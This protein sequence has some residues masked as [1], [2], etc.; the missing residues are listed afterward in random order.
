MLTIAK[1]TLSPGKSLFK[2]HGIHGSLVEKIKFALYLS[3]STSRN[4]FNLLQEIVF[5][6]LK[7]VVNILKMYCVKHNV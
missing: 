4:S 2:L 6:Y 5:V 1:T 3:K 7:C